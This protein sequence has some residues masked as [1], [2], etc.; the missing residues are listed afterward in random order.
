MESREINT[1]TEIK[2]PND[3]KMTCHALILD[4]FSKI[5]LFSRDL[6]GID[7]TLSSTV[8]LEFKLL[9]NSESFSFE[10]ILLAPLIKK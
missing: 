4:E 9:L 2:K 5:L 7:S 10:I 8:L 6:S 3:R 1:I